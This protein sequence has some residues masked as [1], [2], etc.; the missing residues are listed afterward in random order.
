MPGAVAPAVGIEGMN[1]QPTSSEGGEAQ[2]LQPPSPLRDSVSNATQRIHAI[3][4]AAEKAAAGIIED[5]EAQAQRYLEESRRRSE[6]LAEERARE[7]AEVT[8]SLVERAESVKRQADELIAA[9]GSARRQLEERAPDELASTPAPAGSSPAGTQ[10]APA[11]H[12]KSV[13]PVAAPGAAGA[14]PGEPTAGARLLATQMAVAGS[15]R[16]EI[17]NRLRSEFGIE[18]AGP[19]LDAILGPQP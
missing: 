4:D 2:P 12:L 13:E 8:D 1:E 19:M 15:S 18:D 17:E 10:R 7:I 16:P 5:A 3:I 9:L 11:P 6:R 14:V